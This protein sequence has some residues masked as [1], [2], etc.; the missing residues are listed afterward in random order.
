[1]LIAACHA[2]AL[3]LADARLSL[4]DFDAIEIHEAF[5]GQVLA[6]L[7]A[8]ADP[9]F[10]REHL[11]LKNALGVIDRARLNVKGGSLAFGH[12]FAATG[13]RMLATLAKTLDET[14]GR[15]GLIAI[16]TADGM[17]VAAILER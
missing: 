2:V 14:R 8:W 11:G 15:R 3:L 6:T 7:A 12:P 10:C 5:A 17:G 1:L 9:G 13:A 16:C 4:Q